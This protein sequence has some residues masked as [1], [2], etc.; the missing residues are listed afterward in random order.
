MCGIRAFRIFIELT[1][2]SISD[3]FNGRLPSWG[4]ISNRENMKMDLLLKSDH[5]TLKRDRTKRLR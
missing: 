1:H 2:L 5:R 3:T 4:N